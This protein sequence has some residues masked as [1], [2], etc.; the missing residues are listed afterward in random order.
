MRVPV[1]EVLLPADQL[2]TVHFVGIGGAGLSG[3]ARIML[4]TFGLSSDS[5]TNMFSRYLSQWPE[6]FH[7]WAS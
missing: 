3:I 7:S 5:V 4:A 6:I 1:P 2:G